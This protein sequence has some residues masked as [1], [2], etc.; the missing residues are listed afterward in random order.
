MQAFAN[1]LINYY[2]EMPEDALGKVG[3][4]RHVKVAIIDDGINLDFPEFTAMA[5]SDIQGQSFYKV[6]EHQ[7]LQP[8]WYSSSKNHGTLMARLICCICPKVQ[9]YIA[10]LHEGP[11]A[12]GARQIT[13][14]SAEKVNNTSTCY[15]AWVQQQFFLSRN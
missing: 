14:E 15:M 7:N 8:A 9:L 3:R 6:N 5:K 2:N 4:D 11:T 13:A 1:F 10:R 12:G